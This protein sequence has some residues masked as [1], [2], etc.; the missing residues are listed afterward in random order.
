MKLTNKHLR[1]IIKEELKKVLNEDVSNLI[2]HSIESVK[3][4]DS[5]S[6]P[7]IYDGALMEAYSPFAAPLLFEYFG[8]TIG[9]TIIKKIINIV[10]DDLITFCL[11]PSGFQAQELLK[12]YDSKFKGFA[13][14]HLIFDD[15]GDT[16]VYVQIGPN[17]LKIVEG[18]EN[19]ESNGMLQVGLGYGYAPKFNYNSIINP[20][21]RMY[22]TYFSDMDIGDGGYGNQDIQGSVTVNINKIIEDVNS[23]KLAID[24]DGQYEGSIT[25]KIGMS[26][27]A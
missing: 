24:I 14:G 13:V 12:V 9:E 26:Y 6:I 5:A 7:L 16:Y 4:G 17:G 19:I 3:D 1:L 10:D 23:G 22:D 15:E 27:R 11:G 25:Y 20:K 2:I 21:H 8:E 18:Q